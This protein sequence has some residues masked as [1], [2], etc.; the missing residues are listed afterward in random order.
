MDSSLWDGTVTWER[1]TT[2]DDSSESWKEKFVWPERRDNK[3]MEVNGVRLVDMGKTVS[4]WVLDENHP[5]EGEYKHRW[6]PWEESTHLT[7]DERLG[8]GASSC[9]MGE[10]VTTLV[11]HY[12]CKPRDLTEDKDD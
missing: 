1:N 9:K 10:D 2:E 4:F 5:D 6:D 3:L 7:V 12:W 11:T 8:F